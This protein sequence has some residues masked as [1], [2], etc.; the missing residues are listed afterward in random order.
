[1]DPMDENPHRKG[2]AAVGYVIDPECGMVFLRYKPDTAPEGYS[3]FPF[4]MDADGASDFAARWLA[5][6]PYPKEPDHDGDNEKGWR[7]YNEAWGH[8]GKYGHCALIA[9]RPSWQMY[10]K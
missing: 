5:V 1:M 6:A 10:G 8:V 9:V 7:F 3:A 4:P 2:D